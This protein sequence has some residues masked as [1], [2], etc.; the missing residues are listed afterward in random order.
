MSNSFS[1]ARGSDIDRLCD[2]TFLP[3]LLDCGSLVVDLGANHGE[4]A[5]GVIQRFGCH[6]YAAEPL[7]SL[8]EKIEPSPY[9]KLFRVAIGAKDGTVQLRIFR[10]RDAS[11]LGSREQKDV[12]EAEEEVEVVSLG[13]FLSRAGLQRVDLMKVDIEGA[14]LAM[15][16]SASET[17]LAR[18]GQI[19]VEFHDFIYPELKPRVKVVKKRLAAMGFRRINFSLDNTDVLFLNPAWPGMDMSLFQFGKLKYFRRNV[20]GSKRWIHRITAK[21]PY[22]YRAPGC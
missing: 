8:Q 12:L 4:F 2:H 17:D 14:E 21:L 10:S 18:F 20:E 13:T 22:T 6:V 1:I 7:R 16:E 5:H 9:L 3:A 11:V 15:F 19:T